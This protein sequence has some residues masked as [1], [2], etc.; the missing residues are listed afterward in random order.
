[1]A[2]ALAVLALG[3]GLG[4]SLAAPPGPIAAL[5]A[6]RTVH[7][8]FLPG[9]VVMLGATTGDGTHAL[10]MALG[11]MPLIG[12]LPVV[13]ALLTVGGAVLMA[14]FAWGAWRTARRPPRDLGSSAPA[15][16]G[17]FARMGLLPGGFVAG[18]VLAL[19]SPYNFAWWLGAGTTL[20]QDYGAL[21]FASFF[22]GILVWCFVW[23]GIFVAA[24]GR[25]RGLVKG[26]SYASTV[27][28]GAF[29]L[30]LLF[31]GLMALMAAA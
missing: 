27:F 24:R 11:V 26:V 15:E 19:T 5:A 6:E 25:V 29:A 23:A 1:M 30:R 20:F 16:G 31:S 10:L 13:R 14:W 7:R 22:A 2:D 9:V 8:G 18:Y 3:F 12:G 4:L 21:V 17:R 28:L